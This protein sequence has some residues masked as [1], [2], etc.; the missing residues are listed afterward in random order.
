MIFIL[1]GIQQKGHHNSTWPSF[2]GVINIFSY[3]LV[4]I[5]Y[6]LLIISIMEVGV[7]PVEGYFPFISFYFSYEL[8]VLGDYTIYMIVCY[9]YSNHLAIGLKILLLL[10]Y[11]I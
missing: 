6:P 2:L 9:F 3:F 8:F 10:Y 4:N 11:L 1:W 7:D 5:S